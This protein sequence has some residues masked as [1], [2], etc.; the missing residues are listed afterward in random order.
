MP[1]YIINYNNVIQKEK[2][3]KVPPK[4]KPVSDA[5]ARQQLERGL[6]NYTC[7]LDKELSQKT[8][9]LG[10]ERQQTVC[11]LVSTAVSEYIRRQREK[12]ERNQ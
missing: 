3:P 2:Q 4:P 5:A 7:T 9:N 12:Q 10:L 6:Q 1:R 11:A 8:R